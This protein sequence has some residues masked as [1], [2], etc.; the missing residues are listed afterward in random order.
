M[1]QD[2]PPGMLGSNAGLGAGAAYDA[3]FELL[4]AA[5]MQLRNGNYWQVFSKL[6]EAARVARAYALADEAPNEPS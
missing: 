6:Q 1:E 5:E 2:S 4:A 3:V